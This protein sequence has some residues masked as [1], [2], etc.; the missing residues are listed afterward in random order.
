MLWRS[1][2]ACKQRSDQNFEEKLEATNDLVRTVSE[3][4]KA[5]RNNGIAT[6]ALR[7]R[8]I[9]LVPGRAEGRDAKM[10]NYRSCGVN[11]SAD[12]VC[13]LSL[14]IARLAVAKWLYFFGCRKN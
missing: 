10:V 6:K 9:A 7:L 14:Y 8:K 11:I 4:E 12:E 1:N 2:H 5:C 13:H 3:L